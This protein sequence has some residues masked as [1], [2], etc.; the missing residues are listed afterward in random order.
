MS[1]SPIEQ[2]DIQRE[3]DRFVGADPDPVSVILEIANLVFRQ[4]HL[5]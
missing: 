2:F 3:K 5:L 1:A 4:D